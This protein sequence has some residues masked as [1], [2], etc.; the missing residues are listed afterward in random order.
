MAS[1]LDFAS[2]SLS[3]S[4]TSNADSR[5]TISSYLPYTP[6]PLIKSRR[7][8]S[9]MAPI[10][11]S[12]NSIFARSTIRGAPFSSKNDTSASPVSRFIIA[13]SVLKA[14]FS[15]IVLAVALTVSLSFG[16]N[17]RNACCI[18][19]PSW[20]NMFTGMSVG[21]CVTKYIPTPLLRISLI[22]CSILST[23]AFDV[24]SNSICAS[25]KKNTSLGLSKS[26]TSGSVVYNSESSHS[27][28]VEYNFG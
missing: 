8:P 5:S 10:W 17:A 18:L 2:C 15:R 7:W 22:T 6:E 16:V 4:S 21:L 19:L 14:G 12:G 1:A 11:L 27:R 20:P 3:A 9:V 24:S 25:S 23:S 13:S 26:P 28:N